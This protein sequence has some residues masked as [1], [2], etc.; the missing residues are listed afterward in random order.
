MFKHL[1]ELAIQI[2]EWA[3][4]LGGYIVEC[5]LSGWEILRYR[6]IRIRIEVLVANATRRRRLERKLRAGLRTLQRVLGQPSSGEI[7]ILVQQVI[8]TDRQL[9]GCC[10][11]AHRPDGT[12]SALWRLAL[13][14]NGRRLDSDDLLAVLAEQWIALRSQQSDSGVLIPV[15]LEPQAPVPS[16]PSPTLRPD[17]FMPHGDGAYSHRA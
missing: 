3:W 1:G 13:Q 5:L 9:A 16:R 7:T 11:L 10:H 2:I 4:A 17:P 8:T 14:V 6:D 12:P 15:D